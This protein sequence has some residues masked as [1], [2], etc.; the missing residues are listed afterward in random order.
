MLGAHG[1]AWRIGSDCGHLLAIR[2]IRE[3]VLCVFMCLL[4]LVERRIGSR[5]E[6]LEHMD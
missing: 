4:S 5:D 2:P 3:C 1:S 6:G